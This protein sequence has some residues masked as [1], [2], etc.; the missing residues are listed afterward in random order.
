M[1]WLLLYLATIVGVLLVLYLSWRSQPTLSSTWLVPAWLAKWADTQENEN[2]RTGVPFV[3]LGLLIGTRL[4]ASGQ[5]WYRWFFWW[6]CLVFLVTIAEV[7]QLVMP[8]RVFDWRD[9]FCGGIGAII[10]LLLAATIAFMW[11]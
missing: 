10:G 11:K 6:L 5:K 7:A 2:L 1:R 4:S 3:F 9:I 8:F